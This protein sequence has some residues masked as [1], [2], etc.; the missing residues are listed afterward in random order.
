[1]INHYDAFISYRHLPE[2]KIVAIKLQNYL[3]SLKI[4]D[5]KTG[6]KRHLRI[7]RDQS[8][9]FT[10]NDL[11]TNIRAALECSDFLIILYSLTTKESKWCMEEL[12]YF[13]SLHA[14]TNC[15]IL[16]LIIEGE[17]DE[18]FP[19]VLRREERRVTTENGE[20]RVIQVEVEPLGA[21]IRESSLSLKLRKLKKTEY[22]RIAAPVIGCGFDELYRRNFRR[23]VWC[24]DCRFCAAGL[25]SRISIN[26]QTA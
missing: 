4:K 18:V 19:E 5:I 12:N 20:S 15:K 3:E 2:D 22:M 10:S 6:K 14:N 8:E 1:M 21:D 24:T 16:P 26:L 11:G 9:L 17:P 13:R 7:F 23:R 25:L